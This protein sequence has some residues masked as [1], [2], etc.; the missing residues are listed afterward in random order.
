MARGWKFQI[1]EKEGLFYPWFYLC[2]ENIGA[3]QLCGKRF[4][5]A[6]SR[7]AHDVA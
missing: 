3:D 7:F 6:E 2:S 4:A 1:Q 5:Y